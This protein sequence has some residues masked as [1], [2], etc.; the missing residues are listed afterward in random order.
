VDTADPP[1]GA[2]FGLVT[3]AHPRQVYFVNDDSNTL[4]ALR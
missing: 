2:L 3:T 1:G 4:N